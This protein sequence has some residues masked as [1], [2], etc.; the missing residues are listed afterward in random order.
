MAFPLTTVSPTKKPRKSK[1][2]SASLSTVADTFVMECE[3]AD[4]DL[5]TQVK[6]KSRYSPMK[7]SSLAV[8]IGTPP[9][10]KNRQGPRTTLPLPVAFSQELRSQQGQDS[11]ISSLS[12]NNSL[13]QGSFSQHV[14]SHSSAVMSQSPHDAPHTTKSLQDS[15]QRELMQANL[16]I[17]S[18]KGYM[19]LKPNHPQPSYSPDMSNMSSP[20]R[21]L[22]SSHSPEPSQVSENPSHLAHHFPK[23]SVSTPALSRSESQNIFNPAFSTADS[24]VRQTNYQSNQYS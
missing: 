24:T 22:L 1:N 16:H 2:D 7:S 19:S 4:S 5:P 9:L 3:S 20:E 10:D 8:R 17:S 12:D 13:N 11:F 23:Q 18:D 14:Y 21:Q 6:L 15:Q